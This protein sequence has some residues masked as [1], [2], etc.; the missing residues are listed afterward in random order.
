MG[1]DRR[2]STEEKRKRTNP[3]VVNQAGQGDI[4][5]PLLQHPLHF[6]RRPCHAS[7]RVGHV[8]QQRDHSPRVGLHQAIHV[9][10]AP[11]ARKYQEALRGQLGS[12]MPANACARPSNDDGSPRGRD[13][14]GG[15]G[16]V[17]EDAE[18]EGKEDGDDGERK[19]AREERG[20]GRGRSTGGR[21]GA[22]C[23]VSC[24]YMCCGCVLAWDE[25]QQEEMEKH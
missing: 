5:P 16:H 22:G 24:V 25:Q 7:L 17:A 11:D 9:A 3:S 6:L 19:I 2:N 1:R 13:G 23:G 10:Q 4:A 21:H 15:L 12:R 20:G 14:E 8:Q 18:E